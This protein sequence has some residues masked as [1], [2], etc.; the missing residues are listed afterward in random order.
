VNFFKL[1]LIISLFFVYSCASDFYQVPIAQGN[2][3]SLGMLAKL[4]IGLTKAQVQYI[5]GTPSVKDPFNPNQWDY[6]GFEIIGDELLREVHHSLI[7]E[8]NKLKTWDRKL[9]SSS[10][11]DIEKK[12]KTLSKE[13]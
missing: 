3:V 1:P 12:A 6:I 9:E 4:E 13:K 8:D 2:I 10:N 11:D 5:M 7:F